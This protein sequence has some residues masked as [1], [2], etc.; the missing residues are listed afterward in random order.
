MLFQHFFPHVIFIY[1]FY[2]KIKLVIAS[3]RYQIYSRKMPLKVSIIH[4]K[5]IDGIIVGFIKRLNHW[6]YK[7]TQHSGLQE[8]LIRKQARCMHNKEVAA[9]KWKSEATS[10]DCINEPKQTCHQYKYD[11]LTRKSGKN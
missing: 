6:A 5:L 2:W 3:H 4:G 8:T 11:K 10:K 9:L 1:L 7:S